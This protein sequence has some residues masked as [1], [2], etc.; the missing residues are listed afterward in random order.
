MKG[1]NLLEAIR[2]ALKKLLVKTAPSRPKRI[3][4]PLAFFA[5]V[6]QLSFSQVSEMTRGGGL[7]NL[8]HRNNVTNAKL[9]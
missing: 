5:R 8:Q 3:V 1:T 6:N 2:K 7:G 4:N 9:A